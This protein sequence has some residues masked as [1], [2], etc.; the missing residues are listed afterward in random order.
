MHRRS[1]GLALATSQQLILHR[2]NRCLA[3]ADV[4]PAVSVHIPSDLFNLARKL[5]ANLGA[6]REYALGTA[7]DVTRTEHITLVGAEGS[8]EDHSTLWLGRGQAV[9]SYEAAVNQQ[10]V[11]N[12]I[13]LYN[14]KI[15]D[16]S[17]IHNPS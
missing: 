11:N 2:T 12:D 17:R 6:A 16:W 10:R 7:H 13:S 14:G 9:P 15:K 3:S 1:G 5:K 8:E 4:G